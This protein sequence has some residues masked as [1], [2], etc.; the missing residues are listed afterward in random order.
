MHKLKS[1][2][3]MLSRDNYCSPFDEFLGVYV[4][5]ESFVAKDTF[6]I[7]SRTQRTVGSQ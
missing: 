4:G 1:L 5:G 7:K 6:I 2:I 3:I